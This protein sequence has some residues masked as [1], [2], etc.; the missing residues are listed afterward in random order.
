MRVA[1][2]RSAFLRLIEE[3]R[4]VKKN[5][6]EERTFHRAE[7]CAPAHAV[8]VR[9]EGPGRGAGTDHRIARIRR[10]PG[11]SAPITFPAG[12]VGRQN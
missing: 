2:L 11:W 12:L 10:S 1:R 8:L 5:T 7:R 3:R 6:R 4:R 9:P